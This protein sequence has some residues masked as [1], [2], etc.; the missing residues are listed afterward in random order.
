MKRKRLLTLLGSVCLTLML[1]VPLAVSCGPAMPEEAAA[2]IAAVESKLA[3]EKAKVSGLQGDVSD[4]EAEIAALRAPEEA[5]EWKFS[6]WANRG[7]FPCDEIDHPFVDTI[8]AASG[9]R[10]DIKFYGVAE[11]VESDELFTATK[12]G[13][14]DMATSC[15]YHVGEL[16][17]NEVEYNLPMGLPELIQHYILWYER[18]AYEL[19]QEAYLPHNLWLLPPQIGSELPLL[20]TQKEIR[21]LADIEGCTFRAYGSHAT[22]LER[23]GATIV[24]VP[25]AELYTALSTGV[26]E[27]VGNPAISEDVDLKLYEVTS[28]LI[29]PMLMPNFTVDCFVNLDS[30]NALPAHLQAIVTSAAM[31]ASILCN[32]KYIYKDQEGRAIMEAEGVEFIT[33]PPEDVVTMREIAYGIWDE[34]GAKDPSG[35]GTKFVNMTKEYMEFLGY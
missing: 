29:L 26:I 21:T 20:I 3:A 17:F 35:Y 7:M 18:G 28:Y 27:G 16:P 11:L 2:E 1:A 14:L 24:W 32:Q 5:I 6:A 25:F 13:T 22:M 4:L 8:V 30:W 31:D 9:G 23:L 19:A 33:L 12:V 15:G 34:M 10:L